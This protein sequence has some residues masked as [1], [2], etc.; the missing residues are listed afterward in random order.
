MRGLI[1]RARDSGGARLTSLRMGGFV[2]TVSDV[3][4]AVPMRVWV[5]GDNY[6]DPLDELAEQAVQAGSP[7]A[8]D[9]SGSDA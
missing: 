7:A 6:G 8:G 4:G 3:P 2:V 9:L 1:L 5:R